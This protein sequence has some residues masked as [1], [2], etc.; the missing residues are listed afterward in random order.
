MTGVQTC[1]LPISPILKQGDNQFK[2]RV[3]VAVSSHFFGW[4]M[5]LERVKIIGPDDVVEKMKKQLMEQ[6]NMYFMEDEL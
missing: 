3:K 5:A 1:A 2:A 4:V 6:Y